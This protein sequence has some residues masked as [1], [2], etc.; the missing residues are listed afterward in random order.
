VKPISLNSVFPPL[1]A[2]GFLPLCMHA[3]GP[4]YR[5]V[6]VEYFDAMGLIVGW[7]RS[8]CE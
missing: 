7:V 1:S 2:S 5:G 6:V 4:G 3:E 8:L